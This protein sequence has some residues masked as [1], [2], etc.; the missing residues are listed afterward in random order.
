MSTSLLNAEIA[1]SKELGDYWSSTT[2]GAG[3]STTL[4]DSALKAKTDDWLTD[5]AYVILLEEPAGSAAIYDIRK[6]TSLDASAG[7]ITT[8][9]FAAAPGTGIDYSLHRLFSPAEKKRALIKAAQEMV[10]P[11]LFKEIWDESLVSGNWLKDGS[12][13][14][15]DDANTLTDWT[16]TTATATRTSTAGYVR[17]GTYSCKLNTAA[18]TVAVTISNDADLQFLR[19]R[20]VTFTLQAYCDT[21]DA[22][23]LSINDGTTQTYSDYLDGDSMW[24]EDNPRNDSF[25]VT[26]Y[27]DPNATEVTITIHFESAAATAYIDD[28]RLLSDP[29]AKLYVGHL[30]LAQDRPAKIEMEPEYYGHDEPWITLRDYV[31]DDDGYLYIPTKYMSDRRIRILGRGYL[32]FLDSSGDS[33]TDWTATINIDSPQLSILVAYAALYLYQTMSLP[34][35]ETGTRQAFQE[36]VSYWAQQI[37]DRQSK[38]SM[39]GRAGATV[40]WGH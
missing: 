28:A 20:N 19:G 4:V 26:Q 32:D 22:L 31:V 1:L 40:H 13:E 39:R 37:S 36:S 23:R 6:A 18:G 30:G 12:F 38:F 11:A 2:D 17:H 35:Y 16:I 27:I 21:D 25:Y 3:D 8:L 9:A 15:W 24:T 10:Y 33:A 34:N 7:E 5:E 14:R 29:R